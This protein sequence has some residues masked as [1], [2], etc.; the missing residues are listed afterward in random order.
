MVTIRLPDGSTREVDHDAL[1]DWGADF[2]WY[3]VDEN[4]K[5]HLDHFDLFNQNPGA[6]PL[7]GEP[8]RGRI[9][10]DVLKAAALF[11]EQCPD[12]PQVEQIQGDPLLKKSVY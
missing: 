4:G 5:P 2:G 9:R 3:S 7:T 8:W 11:Q 12:S 6:H 1:I 10:P